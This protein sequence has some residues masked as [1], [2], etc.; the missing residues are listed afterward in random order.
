MSITKQKNSIFICAIVLFVMI[1]FFGLI[2][3]L[4][5]KQEVQEEAVIYE[6]KD[7]QLDFMEGLPE[8]WVKGIKLI[9]DDNMTS[10][11]KYLVYED[12]IWMRGYYENTFYH[13]L[14]HRIYSILL[15]NGQRG[16]LRDIY[17][18]SSDEEFITSY[19]STN[20]REDFAETFEEYMMSKGHGNEPN[21][22]GRRRRFLDNLFSENNWSIGKINP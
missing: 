13:E 22:E 4:P 17:D 16:Y 1:V 2:L 11:G 20:H 6:K 15:T 12:E 5:D 7:F 3:F 14:G 9:I 8:E 19:A 10:R 18:T 21:I